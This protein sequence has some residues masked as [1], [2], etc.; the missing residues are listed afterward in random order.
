MGEPITGR[1]LGELLGQL[2]ATLGKPYGQKGEKMLAGYMKGLEDWPA[3]AIEW[4]VWRACKLWKQKHFPKPAE[5]AELC[6]QSPHPRIVRDAEKKSDV[7]EAVRCPECGEWWG[8]HRVV[9]LREPDQPAL[10]VIVPLVRHRDGC[11]FR[12]WE[13][14]RNRLY[15]WS[16]CDGIP[17][18]GKLEA[19]GIAWTVPGVYPLVDPLPES[20]DEREK[21]LARERPRRRLDAEPTRGRG[22][23]P[24]ALGAVLPAAQK[25]LPPPRATVDEP[26]V[27]AAPAASAPPPARSSAYQPG[28]DPTWEPGAPPEMEYSL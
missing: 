19:G 9:S 7:P 6:A 13:N 26:P 14:R 18:R 3:E 15:A 22:G 1:Y 12:N 28:L 10:L 2:A 11:P 4:A 21:R 8:W 17:P 24:A 23:P 20:L 5:L 16:W 27:L 25:T